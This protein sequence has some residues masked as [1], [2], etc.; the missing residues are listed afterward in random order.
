MDG[1]DTGTRPR[2]AIPRMSAS[3]LVKMKRKTWRLP[4]SLRRG[5]KCATAAGRKFR[6]LKHQPS[7]SGE[8]LQSVSEY[9]GSMPIVWPLVLDPPPEFTAAWLRTHRAWVELAME[10]IEVHGCTHSGR[11]R[12]GL[13]GRARQ[14]HH[15]DRCSAWPL[16]WQS[17]ALSALQLRYPCVLLFPPRPRPAGI[18]HGSMTCTHRLAHCLPVLICLCAGQPVECSVH[19]LGVTHGSPTNPRAVHEV[20]SAV[21]PDAF[22]M[23]GTEEYR[24]FIR[25]AAG[26]THLQ[27]LLDK[28]GRTA[29]SKEGSEEYRGFIRLTEKDSS[30]CLKARRLYAT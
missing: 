30:P 10:P 4:S 19:L 25:R 12:R 16:E 20:A 1:N 11:L 5:I 7:S 18:A 14:Y 22:A 23:E 2:P 21:Q 13:G 27:P 15:G 17:A 6:K 3:S 26:S 8:P 29:G 24:G 9:S 28:V